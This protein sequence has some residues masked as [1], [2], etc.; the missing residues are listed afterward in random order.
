MVALVKIGCFMQS[1]RTI[2]LWHLAHRGRKAEAFIPSY[3]NPPWRDLSPW[4]CPA[5]LN[6]CRTLID[7]LR[8]GHYSSGSA[9]FGFVF[10]SLFFELFLEYL[11]AA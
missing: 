2:A 6:D 8:R 11:P 7:I 9:G 1:A 5:S 4:Q 10:L 3:G